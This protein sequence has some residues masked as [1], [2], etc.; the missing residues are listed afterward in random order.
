M[1][2]ENSAPKSFAKD[3]TKKIVTYSLVNGHWC[4]ENEVTNEPTIPETTARLYFNYCL[5]LI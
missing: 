5:L 2:S 3:G 1:S 4:M